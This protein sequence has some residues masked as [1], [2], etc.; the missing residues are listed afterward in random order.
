MVILF[1]TWLLLGWQYPNWLWIFC[2]IIFIYYVF[3]RFRRLFNAIKYGGTNSKKLTGVTKGLPA[4]FALALLFGKNLEGTVL[5]ADGDGW[6]L[7]LIFLISHILLD[8]NTIQVNGTKK[9]NN[10]T[11]DDSKEEINSETE[12][13]YL[14]IVLINS[15]DGKKNTFK[16]NLSNMNFINKF[17]INKFKHKLLNEDIDLEEI[18]KQTKE[19][20]QIGTILDIEQEEQRVIISIE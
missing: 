1:T 19:N 18:L 14:K 10:G 15:D 20:P 11:K 6:I 4:S 12:G 13:F 5:L 16:L 8:D 7:F 17:I 9:N 2:G 3:N